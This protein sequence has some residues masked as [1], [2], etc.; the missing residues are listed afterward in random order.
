MTTCPFCDSEISA[1]DAAFCSY[2]GVTLQR[3]GALAGATDRLRELGGEIRMLSVFFVNFSG[4]ETLVDQQI[5]KDV[6]INLREC[7]A[8]VET[9]IRSFKGTA[10]QIVADTR[11]LAVFG[12]PKA[13]KDD[14]L[15]ALR[16]ALEIKNWWT[17]KKKDK[18]LLRDITMTIGVHTGRAFFGYI[19]E[20]YSFL[21]VIG[22]NINIAARL[23]GLC[24]ADEILISDI[25]NGLND[26]TIIGRII[27]I[28]PPKKRVDFSE[29]RSIPFN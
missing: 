18:V 16:C 11:V 20:E 9:F 29:L 14:P 15:R 6:M 5:D 26:V 13:H 4:F 8:E 1:E 3:E 17:H 19:I 24:P 23:T 10:N 12:A 22:D 28:Y 2:C 27:I 7:L 21:T 25:I